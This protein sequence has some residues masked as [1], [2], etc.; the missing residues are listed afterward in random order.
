MRGV[1]PVT[2][3]PINPNYPSFN[4]VNHI[5]SFHNAKK[6]FLLLSLEPVLQ[7]S[8]VSALKHAAGPFL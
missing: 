5:V 8:P 3:D 1:P 7:F 6:L 4:N 2:F